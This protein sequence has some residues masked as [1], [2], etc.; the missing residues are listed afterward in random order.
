MAKM[1]QHS[2]HFVRVDR[3]SEKVLK[4][5]IEITLPVCVK[6]VNYFSLGFYLVVCN[7]R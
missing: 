7:P 3:L 1:R 2:C 4:S 6:T 5:S